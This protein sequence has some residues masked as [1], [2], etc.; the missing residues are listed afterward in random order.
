MKVSKLFALGLVALTA[1]AVSTPN[2]VVATTSSV[3]VQPWLCAV[4]QSNKKGGTT[5]DSTV[6]FM[7][8]FWGSRLPLYLSIY[9][10]DIGGV[11]F[12]GLGSSTPGTSLS[13]AVS[14]GAGFTTGNKATGTVQNVHII[15]KGKA[16]KTTPYSDCFLSH[17]VVYAS[18]RWPGVDL[19]FRNYE[20]EALAFC[21]GP[22]IPPCDVQLL[23]YY[24]DGLLANENAATFEIANAAAAPAALAALA[25]KNPSCFPPTNTITSFEYDTPT[26]TSGSAA[27]G[28]LM[29]S[30]DLTKQVAAGAT[31]TSLLIEVSSTSET[32]QCQLDTFVLNGGSQASKTVTSAGCISH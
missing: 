11:T 1:V 7:N 21:G 2:R 6:Q 13:F 20:N 22:L 30:Y 4:S 14:P 31:L 3:S 15:V 5:V 10:G 8:E 17:F 23:P 26:S 27:Q 28:N 18:S 32:G 9:P 19:D 16:S 24:I 12:T 25:D 29:Y